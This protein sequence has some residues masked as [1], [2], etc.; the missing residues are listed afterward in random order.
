[1]NT[2]I[3]MAIDEKKGCLISLISLLKRRFYH[4]KKKSKTIG[5]KIKIDF[6]GIEGYYDNKYKYHEHE[7]HDDHHSHYGYSKSYYQSY[8]LGKIKNNRRLKI[9]VGFAAI[10]LFAVVLVL[11]IILIPLIIKLV[12][13]INQ[14]GIQGVVDNI[15]GFLNRIWSGLGK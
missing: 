6:M 9:W 1:M 4:L 7:Y 8:I 13:F 5:F 14:H 2:I 11:L 12:N 3:R 15:S 10:F